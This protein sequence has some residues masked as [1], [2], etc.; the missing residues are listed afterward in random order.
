VRNIRIADRREWDV[1]RPVA[2]K[3]RRHQRLVDTIATLPILLLVPALVLVVWPAAAGRSPALHVRSTTVE[4]GDAITVRG[5]GFP[6]SSDG[7][8][9]WDG[10]TDGMPAFEVSRRGDF[11]V[12]VRIP[13][14]DRG[15]THVLSALVVKAASDPAA[16]GSPEDAATSPEESMVELASIKLVIAEA[17]AATPTPTPQPT[18]TPTPNPT[19][20]PTP[21]P[22]ATA[23]PAPTATPT[24][25]PTATQT[26][27]PTATPTTAPTAIPTATPTQAPTTA[28]TATPTTA[29]TATPVGQTPFGGTPVSLPGRIEAERYDIG[30][31][32]ASFADADAANL[33]GAFRTDAVDIKVAEGYTVGWVQAGEWLETTVTVTAGTYDIRARVASPTTGGTFHLELD[34]TTIGSQ[35]TVPATGSWATQ[36]TVTVGRGITLPAGTHVLRF[37]ADA[38]G[39]VAGYVGDLNWIEVGT[40]TV[41]AAPTPTPTP[42]AS[43]TPAPTPTPTASA[44]P[45]PTVAPTASPTPAPAGS[46]VASLQTA[47]NNTPTGGTLVLGACTF[48]E[49]V[50]VTRSMTIRGPAIIDGSGTRT[51]WMSIRAN[52]VVIDGLTMRNAAQG[53][54]QSSSLD[55]YNSDRVTVRNVDLSGGSYSNI[56][57]WNG[58]D[59]GVVENSTIHHGRAVGIH[60]WDADRLAVRGNRIYDNNLARVGDPGWEA[61]GVKLA[62]GSGLV[63]ANNDVFGNLGPGLW[64]DVDC[65]STTFSGNRIHHNTHSGI[66]F[67][68]SDGAIITGNVLWENGWGGS[69]WAYGASIQ[70]SSSRN[71]TVRGNT[72]AWSSRGISVIAQN[73]GSWPATA[74]GSYDHIVVEDNTVINSTGTW[75]TAWVDDRSGTPLFG[76]SGNAGRSNTYWSSV[77]EARTDRYHWA[78]SKDTLAA[79]NSTPGEESGRYLTIAERDSRLVAAGIPISPLAH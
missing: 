35:T 41:T 61:G 77:S 75:M 20:T 8:I 70:V 52:D 18:A 16:S 71:V 14:E 42:A 65:R 30:G 40:P 73:R 66:F 4:P 34:G 79:F 50:S 5:T 72:V 51:S 63:F 76:A 12:S 44:T 47:I 59:D 58:S 24:A 22:T 39:S 2:R 68:I 62:L 25:V 29:P 54:T 53:A 21:R 28:P 43:S 67:E 9:A 27:A 23:T 55:V 49:S 17:P 10:D 69:S 38:N 13:K 36:T 37:K 7:T 78:G 3:P 74:P 57:F 32:G 26:T 15:S 60:S 64:C 19:A 56:R 33:G 31:S 48:R 45:A 6:K 11:R 46:C 1:N